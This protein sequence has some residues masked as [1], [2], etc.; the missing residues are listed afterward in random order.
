MLLQPF[1]VWPSRT[2]TSNSSITPRTT[3]RLSMKP[4]TATRNILFVVALYS[5]LNTVSSVDPFSLLGLAV[6]GGDMVEKDRR[7]RGES[8]LS[9]CRARRAEVARRA[10]GR[11]RSIVLGGVSGVFG[12]QGD[13]RAGTYK[14]QGKSGS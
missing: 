1:I 8:S 5:V 9:T 4:L 14:E 3:L 10:V 11:G 7:T 6:V 2:S 13:V 12:G